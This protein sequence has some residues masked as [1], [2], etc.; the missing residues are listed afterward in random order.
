MNSV[1]PQSNMAATQRTASSGTAEV[2]VI[3]IHNRVMGSTLVY[4]DSRL[5]KIEYQQLT[6]D[7]AP[8]IVAR[9]FNSIYEDEGAQETQL[10]VPVVDGIQLNGR[11]GLTPFLQEKLIRFNPGFKPHQ[12]Y[13]AREVVAA[14]A[15]GEI[16]ITATGELFRY[17]VVNLNQISLPV[18]TNQ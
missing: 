13:S 7:N 12:F 10:F 16:T 17:A 5:F 15:I 18:T 2:A 3:G 6:G 9:N 8:S 14:G 4:Y 11:D 1:V